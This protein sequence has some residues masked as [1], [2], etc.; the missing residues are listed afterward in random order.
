MAESHR[1]KATWL[2]GN[3]GPEYILY[4]PGPQPH[5]IKIADEI[6]MHKIDLTFIFSSFFRNTKQ[7]TYYQRNTCLKAPTPRWSLLF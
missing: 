7:I 5:R 6:K 4:V 2:L 1:K 3:R